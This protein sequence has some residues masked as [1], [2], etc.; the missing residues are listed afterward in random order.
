MKD[1]FDRHVG[2][3]SA[4]WRTA[5]GIK[6]RP[7]YLQRVNELQR[8]AE[9]GHTESYYDL[10]WL[11]KDG[12]L[13]TR[14]RYV[15]KPALKKAVYY[16]AKAAEGGHSGALLALGYCYD[17]AQG[18][19]QNTEKALLCYTKVWKVHHDPTAA[20]NIAAIHRDLGNLRLAF[21]WWRKVADTGIDG[22]AFVDI[23]YC[24]YYGI[25]VKAQQSKALAAFRHACRSKFIIEF[26]REEA[27]YHLAVA[28]LDQTNGH[29]IQRARK[30]LL[31]AN[32]DDDYPE[33]RELLAQ[34]DNKSVPVPCRCR[35]FLKRSILG[36][37][38]CVLHRP[39]KKMALS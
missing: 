35:R 5:H 4:K 25:G 7:Y 10:G 36:Q 3:A 28:S 33:A 2:I 30:L 13:D 23:G 26:G 22:D 39:L 18:V 31:K 29:N 24:L 34:L 8:A 12:V 19:G 1:E 11:L 37:S 20:L 17:N 6:H 9:S 14:G 21:R 16:F 15:V 32:V 38:A 27:F